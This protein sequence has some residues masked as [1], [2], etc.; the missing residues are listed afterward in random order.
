MSI[1]NLLCCK[2]SPIFPH[3]CPDSRVV[4]L[5]L[6]LLA[7]SVAVGNWTV[8][9]GNENVKNIYILYQLS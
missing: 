9:H 1:E 5:R 7:V 3:L 2:F 8:P 6:A 4:T